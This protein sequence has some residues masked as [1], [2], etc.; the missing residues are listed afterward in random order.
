MADRKPHPSTHGNMC[1]ISLQYASGK[2]SEPGTRSL[3]SDS[4]DV[5]GP[6]LPAP[7]LPSSGPHYGPL[8]RPN[9]RPGLA[10]IGLGLS[11][12][13]VPDPPPRDQY[14]REDHLLDQRRHP[15]CLGGGRFLPATLAG[16][17]ILQVD[18][19]TSKDQEDDVRNGVVG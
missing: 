9:D 12:S 11:G 8:L 14:R 19:G 1:Q 13:L 7:L 16:G 10:G 3:Q 2:R 17:T 18:H 6:E 5:K 4:W 15:L